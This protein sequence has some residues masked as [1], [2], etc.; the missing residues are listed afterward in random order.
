MTKKLQ[1]IDVINTNKTVRIK[2]MYM[3]VVFILWH[4]R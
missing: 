1:Q 3:I 4:Y 2:D